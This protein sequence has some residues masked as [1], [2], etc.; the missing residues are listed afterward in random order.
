MKKKLMLVAFVVVTICG[1]LTAKQGGDVELLYLGCSCCEGSY[2]T[3]CFVTID[4]QAVSCGKG[5]NVCD[6]APP[7]N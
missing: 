1:A 2:N 7:I 5:L 4:F 6:V 3:E